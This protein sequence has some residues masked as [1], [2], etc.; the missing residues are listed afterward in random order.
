M[1]KP[2]LLGVLE[3]DSM[4]LDLAGAAMYK[5]R[6][7]KGSTRLSF[8]QISEGKK[9]RNRELA[10][11]VISDVLYRYP[12]PRSVQSADEIRDYMANVMYAP[13]RQAR[14]TTFLWTN[15]L[16]LPNLIT[17]RRPLHFSMNSWNLS[18]ATSMSP[19]QSSH[20]ETR[21]TA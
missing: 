18:Q 13:W 4:L 11:S 15:A 6:E 14:P 20:L 9:C 1:D 2:A 19:L 3:K 21:Q 17:V 5:T 8:P 10:I 16:F 12:D 7:P